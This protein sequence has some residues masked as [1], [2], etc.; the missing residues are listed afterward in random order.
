MNSVVD[1]VLSGV[2]KYNIKD[3]GGTTIYSNA[4]IELATTVT[5]QRNAIKQS[6][7]R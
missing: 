4:T 6:F 5:T 7:I 2:P 1:A 3:S